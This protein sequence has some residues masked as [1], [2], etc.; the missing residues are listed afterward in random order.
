MGGAMKL[1]GKVAVV[2]GS[3]SGIGETIC[4]RLA[5]EGA[6]VGVLDLDGELARLTADLVGGTAVEADISDSSL[7]DRAL[8]DVEAELGP[9]D[10]WVNNAGIPAIEQAQRINPLAERQL[11]E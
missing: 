9:V 2:T 1:A 11:E 4:R 6:R 7:V 10:I 5:D 3:G 8:V